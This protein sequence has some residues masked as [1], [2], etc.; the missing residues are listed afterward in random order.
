MFDHNGSRQVL[1]FSTIALVTLIL[2]SSLCVFSS[3]AQ[4]EP[5]SNTWFTVA[6]TAVGNYPDGVIGFNIFAVNS[7]MKV[8][9]NISIE[10]MVIVTPWSNY[11]QNSL[12]V[13]L[14]PGEAYSTFINATIPS[15]FSG[16][17]FSANFL[18]NARFWNGSTWIPFTESARIAVQVLSLPNN[19]PLNIWIIVVLVGVI[20]IIL[21]VLFMREGTRHSPLEQ[22]FVEDPKSKN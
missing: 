7:A 19:S 18:A 15:S 14:T 17:S 2:V 12:P 8:G 3:R 5:S 22:S 6:A 9:E 4:I 20:A 1:R 11:S 21:A 13:T 16:S 10:S